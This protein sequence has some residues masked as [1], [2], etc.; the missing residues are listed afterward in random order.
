MD[1]SSSENES[2]YARIQQLEQE[3]DELH[4]DIEQLCMQKGGHGYI[5]FATQTYFRRTA[6]LEQEVENLKNKLADYVKEKTDIK[7]EL[8]EAKRI[9]THLDELYKLEVSK[10]AEVAKQ[11]EYL[12]KI[13]ANAF[14]DRDHALVEAE[15]AKESEELMCQK[16]NDAERRLQELHVGTLKTEEQV[17][18][19]RMKMEKQE[20]E[21]EN[22][23]KI[24]DKFYKIRQCAFRGNIDEDC[25]GGDLLE[26]I[27]WH[28]KCACLYEDPTESWSFDVHQRPSS[29]NYIAALLEEVETLRGSIDD[30]Q[31]KLQMG[32]EIER[33]LKRRVS[34]MKQK[35]ILSDRHIVD[36]ISSLR[37]LH[38]QQ[39][40]HI[41]ELLSNER[42]FQESVVR[43]IEQ[44]IEELHR[45]VSAAEVANSSMPEN[46]QVDGSSETLARALHEKVSALILLSQQEERH[47]LEKNVQSAVQE[48]VDEL[49]KNLKLASEQKVKALMELAEVKQQYQQ[50][51]EKTIHDTPQ[52]HHVANSGERRVVALGRDGKL[53]NLLKKTSLRHWLGTEE[54]FPS[55]VHDKS[56]TEGFPNNQSSNHSFDNAR[57]RIEYVTLK[58]SIQSLERLTSDIRKLRHSLIQAKMACSLKDPSTSTPR[59]VDDT[60]REAELLKI[61]LS[62][63]LPLSWSGEGEVSSSG[64]IIAEENPKRGDSDAEKID[65]VSAA[66]LEMVELLILAGHIMKEK[67]S[68]REPQTKLVTTMENQ[69]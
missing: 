5:S 48:T 44:K 4:K 8:S 55:V 65:P 7:D 68:E 45:D 10:N 67:K 29:S 20:Q 13:I 16:L 52:V 12:R 56:E 57:L 26:N 33:H 38:N 37:E 49:Q 60:I 25:N 53:R 28:D 43:S 14:A 46:A 30:L 15:K 9:K 40:A 32:W 2:L 27:S 36:G 47:I 3:R 59:Q 42:S 6:G 17:M 31:S 18:D 58:D 21:T 1:E 39:R 41:V 64:D 22:F 19:L 24:I 23:K 66:G 69:E 62:S 11:L 35:K 61:A 50:L 34:M 63:A 54:K 51:L